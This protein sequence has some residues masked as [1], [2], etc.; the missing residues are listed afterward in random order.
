VTQPLPLEQLRRRQPLTQKELALA[1]GVSVGTVRGIEH[2]YYK[3]V[4]PRVIRAIAEALGVQPA[5]VVEFRPSLG[6][7]ADAVERIAR[8]ERPERIEPIE[9]DG[10]PDPLPS[11]AA[12]Y[13]SPGA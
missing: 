10:A 4:R 3:S 5:D 13:A 6:L 1:A 12:G 7:S 9:G 11:P 8:V 2:G